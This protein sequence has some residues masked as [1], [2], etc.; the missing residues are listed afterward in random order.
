MSQGLIPQD[1]IE[2]V[3]ERLDIVEVVSAYVSLTRAGQNLKGLCPFHSEKSP[4]FSVSPARQ[5]FHCFGC[6]A[7]G[8]LYDFV[9]RIEGLSFPEAVRKLAHKAGIEIPETS[10]PGQRQT[11]EVRERIRRINESA[12]AHFRRNLTEPGLG[13]QARAYLAERGI[14]T[15]TSEQFH[16]GFSLP[17]WDGLLKALSHAGTTADD[18]L[19]AGLV[20]PREASAGKA[21]QAT[22]CYDRFRNRIM[23]PICDLSGHVIGFG[24]RVMD[25]TP[26]KYLNSS[27]TPLFSKGKTLFALDR[28]REAATRAKSLIL[29]EGYFD[30]VALHQAG[31]RQV[32]ATLGT[33][34]TPDHVQMIRRFVGQVILLFDPDNAGVNAALRA[35]DLFANSGLDVRVIS[36]PKGHDPDTF[37]RQEGVEAFAALQASAPSL[38]TFAVDHC[39]R[40]AEGGG[41]QAKVRGVDAILRTLQKAANRVEQE[42]CLRAV[43][44]RLGVNQVLLVERYRELAAEGR[45]GPVQKPAR[46]PALSSVQTVGSVEERDLAYFLVQGRI[47]AD[48]MRELQPE[49]FASEACRRLV[50]MAKGGVARRGHFELRVWL[51]EAVADP[52]CAPVVTEL[53]LTERHFDDPLEHLQGCVQTLKRKHRESMLRDLVVQLRAAERDGRQDEAE[54]LNTLVNEL[55]L[56]KAGAAVAPQ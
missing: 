34:L 46:Q 43:A 20:V 14:A 48:V 3:K 13:R 26:P 12:A 31:I 28:A 1:I 38:L 30:A 52:I 27:E 11:A 47:T 53:S 17:A 36:L 29:V 45:P 50:E 41:M 37:V 49:W 35:L 6:H 23:F 24:G 39:V 10:T 18:L 8:S 21:G 9:M 7:G 32:A 56:S 51:D 4:S 42:E 44:E 5:F 19:A 25:D 54:R 2:R 40:A 15:A 33:A 16:I 22:G 55:R